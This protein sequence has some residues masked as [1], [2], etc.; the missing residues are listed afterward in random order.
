MTALS[1]TFSASPRSGFTLIEMIT[2][3]AA[4]VILLGLMVSLAR[5]V[6]NRSATELTE[7]VLV[8]VERL[9][10]QYASKNGGHVPDVPAVIPPGTA[11]VSE[12]AIRDI[13]WKNN[14]QFVKSL[15]RMAVM[16]REFGDLPVSMYDETNLKDSW[17][18]P[19]VMM[20]GMHPAIGM[21]AGNRPF[22]FSAGPDGRYLTRDDNLYSYDSSKAGPVEA[23]TP[24]E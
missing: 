15:R 24:E 22:L 5:D 11:V 3:V 4:L 12:E 6:R 7:D 17:G 14:E 18:R 10:W 1:S 9:V 19:I 16:S 20:S 23:T 2:T 13:A 21:A 8:K